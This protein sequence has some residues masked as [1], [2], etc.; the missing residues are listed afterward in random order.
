MTDREKSGLYGHQ[1]SFINVE[2]LLQPLFLNQMQSK[3]VVSTNENVF[4]IVTDIY[5]TIVFDPTN[6]PGS[7]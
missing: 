4:G 1:T 2:K 6:G 3:A 7:F 5:E